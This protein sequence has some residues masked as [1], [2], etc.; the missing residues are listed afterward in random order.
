[1]L[2]HC[3][4]ISELCMQNWTLISDINKQCNNTI[5]LNPY[6]FL[7]FILYFPSLGTCNYKKWIIAIHVL[8]TKKV[9]DS[10]WWCPH[11]VDS[12]FSWYIHT[13]SYSLWN[14]DL[15]FTLDKK[16]NRNV[17]IVNHIGSIF[18]DRCLF[19]NWRILKRTE[20]DCVRSYIFNLIPVMKNRF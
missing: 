7:P 8:V 1:M 16:V 2:L 9:F 11:N 17:Y 15:T 20:K 19:G 18:H 4:F 14:C 6:S 12:F 10:I 13:K 5:F 3:L